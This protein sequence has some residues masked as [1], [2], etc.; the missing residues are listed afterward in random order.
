MT[1]EICQM[2]ME[3]DLG[4]STEG[5]SLRL[6]GTV[7]KGTWRRPRCVPNNTLPLEFVTFPIL[8]KF[9]VG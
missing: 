4:F 5:P 8:V 9:L 6:S 1:I 3:N 2:I 7:L